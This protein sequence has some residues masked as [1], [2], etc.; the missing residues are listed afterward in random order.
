VRRETALG[1]LSALGV[2]VEELRGWVAG[3]AGDNEDN[4]KTTP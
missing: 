4:G 2:S 3:G 1:L